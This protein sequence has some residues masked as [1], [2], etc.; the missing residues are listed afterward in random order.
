MEKEPTR[1][2]LSLQN[3]KLM[4]LLNA[5]DDAPTPPGS[6]TLTEWAAFD[7]WCARYKKWYAGV[8]KLVNEIIDAR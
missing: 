7:S 1:E 3:Y 5:F 8:Q 2:E 6:Y 4:Q